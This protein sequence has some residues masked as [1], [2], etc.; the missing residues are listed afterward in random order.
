MTTAAIKKELHKAIDIVNS[1][2]LLKAI[3]IILNEE[4]KKADEVIKPFTVEEFYARN[5]QSQKE[6]EQGK[7]LTHKSIKAKYSIKK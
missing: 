7:L 3:Y 5:S 2:Q 4:L 1:E 6:I